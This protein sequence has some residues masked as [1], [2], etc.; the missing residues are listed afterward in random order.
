MRHNSLLNITIMD[1]GFEILLP[2]ESKISA[3]NFERPV[4]EWRGEKYHQGREEAR[5]H[6]FKLIRSNVPEHIISLLPDRFRKY[7]WQCISIVEGMDDLRT[8]LS[9]DTMKENGILLSL[10][11]ALTE[12]EKKWVVVF[13]PDYDRINEVIEGKLIDAYY[14]IIESLVVKRNGFVLWAEK[15]D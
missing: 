1:I 4:Y 13:E 14:K 5:F 10:L 8:E 12:S 9:A 11:S 7:Q 2:V 6:Y 15:M 3:I